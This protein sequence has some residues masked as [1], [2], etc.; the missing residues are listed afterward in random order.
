MAHEL[1]DDWRERFVEMVRGAEPLKA[2]WFTGGPALSPM[3]QLEVYH[4]QYRIRLYEALADEVPG[5]T[6]LLGPGAEPYLRAY[7]YDRPSGSWT[8]NR[9][10]HGLVAWMT[11]RGAPQPFLDMAQLDLAVQTGFD[12]ADGEP[13]PPEAFASMPALRLQ[14]HVQLLRLRSNVHWI[15]SASLSGKEAP[16][17][18]EADYGVVVFRRDRKMRHWEMPKGAFAILE[19][20]SLGRSVP[21]AID[22]AFTLGVLNMETLAEDVGVWFKDFSSRNLVELA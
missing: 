2:D 20:I 4:G 5:L 1:P 17:L 8:L 3:E 15:R 10:G 7:L 12:A 22:R 16:E 6:A 9:V 18:V 13:V 14:A 21:E 11:E 19:G